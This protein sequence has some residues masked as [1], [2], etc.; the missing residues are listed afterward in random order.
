MGYR[1]WG[2]KE[3]D[4]TEQLKLSLSRT[5]SLRRAMQ[6]GLH[7]SVLSFTRSLAHSLTPIPSVRCDTG[8][9][10][11]SEANRALRDPQVIRLQ[12]R[13]MLGS[14]GGGNR[15][16]RQSEEGGEDGPCQQTREH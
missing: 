16:T 5:S 6:L 8:H 3:L 7:V 9:T 14:L 2:H 13:E 15:K 4:T 11:D 12:V 10:E 1:P